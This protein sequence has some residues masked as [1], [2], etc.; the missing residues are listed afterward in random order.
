MSGQTH[1]KRFRTRFY[2]GTSGALLIYDLTNAG[3]YR[4][5]QTWLKECQENI[6]KE[7]PLLILGNKLDL[8]DLRVEHPRSEYSSYKS[9]NVSAK[10][11]QNVDEAFFAL[12]EAIAGEELVKGEQFEP[13]TTFIS[14]DDT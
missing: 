14:Y 10:S 5:V 3:S 1:F 4:N 13:K 12:F 2:T 11:G 8:T 7:I 9:Y 6:E